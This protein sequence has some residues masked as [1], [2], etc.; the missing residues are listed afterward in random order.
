MAD[1]LVDT[2][3]WIDYFRYSSGSLGDL[4]ARLLGENR[5]VLCGV[6]EMELLQ[7]V[8]PH[9]RAQL[10]DVLQALPY[11]ETEREDFIAAG[12]RMAQLR[13][14]GITI[15]VTDCLIGVLCARHKLRLLTTDGHFNHFSELSR[16][17]PTIQ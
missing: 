3:V 7:G 16:L 17:D 5:I 9:E 10:Q 6:V 14:R 8:R 15:P 2:S 12:N 11:V 4:V 13:S 1:V